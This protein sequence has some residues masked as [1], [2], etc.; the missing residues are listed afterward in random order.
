MA[1]VISRSD[2][3]VSLSLH[4]AISVT[5]RLYSDCDPS[6]RAAHAPMRLPIPRGSFRVVAGA[7]L[8]ENVMG[9]RLG[10]ASGLAGDASPMVVFDS[11]SG[12]LLA[13][14]PSPSGVLR[15][16]ATVGVATKWLSA[17]ESTTAAILGTGRNAL[18]CLL[19]MAAVR[20]LT[21]IRVF[22]RSPDRRAAFAERA[23]SLVPADV[24][25]VSSSAE[26]VD[27]AQIVTCVTSSG[28]PV[29]DA[30]LLLSSAHVNSVG[31]VS[32]VPD[33]IYVGAAAIFV[34][35]KR[36]EEQF[37][38]YE[39]HYSRAYRHSL[40]QLAREGKVDWEVDVRDLGEAVGAGWT[41]RPSTP[42][43]FKDSRGGIG[44]LALGLEMYKRALASGQG[45]EV[46]FRSATDDTMSA[47][48]GLEQHEN[49]EPAR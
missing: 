37:E 49:E 2:T 35:S 48:A 27:G 1:L 14:M 34:G 17:P 44:D 16:G 12:N 29:F 32:E 33:E 18:S 28:E 43:V 45:M 30:S 42:V 36:Q 7:L 21:D 41:A 10:S 5:E 9:A 13:V 47:S 15:T 23:K 24:R 22:S 6:Q 8:R 3:S 20:R 38:Y 40:L 25:P 26:A 11:E 46:D 4:D 31:S 19:G 39:S